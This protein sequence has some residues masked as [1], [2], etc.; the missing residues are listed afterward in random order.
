MISKNSNSVSK[1]SSLIYSSIN[2]AWKFLNPQK[3][4]TFDS[5]HPPHLYQSECD[6]CLASVFIFVITNELNNFFAYLLSFWILF[7]C[8]WSNP[9]LGHTFVKV[10]IFFL[11]IFR[12]SLGIHPL[13]VLDIASIFSPN[14]NIFHVVLL[15]I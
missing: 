1:I 12:N 10:S 6:W 3:P 2:S 13:L 8:D 15:W 4:P 5:I 11:L 14:A 9:S 7:F